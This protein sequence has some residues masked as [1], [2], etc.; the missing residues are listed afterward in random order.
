M[1]RAL[2]ASL[3]VYVHS[4]LDASAFAHVYGIRNAMNVALVCV[5]KPGGV[6]VWVRLWK[7]K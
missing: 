2:P 5:Y 3:G 1:R 6:Q 7:W 4:V